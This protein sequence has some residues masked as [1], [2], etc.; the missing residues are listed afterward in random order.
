MDALE[1]IFLA[2]GYRDIT[3]KE[4]AKRLGCSFRRLYNIAD[5]KESLFL[6]VIDR[7]FNAMKKSGWAVSSTSKP[8]TTRVTDYLQVGIQAASRAGDGFNRDIAST[9]AG[10]LLFDSL[11]KERIS[12][13]KELVQEGIESG[14]FEKYHAYF[15]A[16]VMIQ[17]TRRVREPDFLAK[18]GM[19][20]SESLEE[21]SKLLRFGLL[22][23]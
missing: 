15:V 16:E 2:E 5:S 12:G 19:T 6:L 23:R 17:V 9:K 11:Q 7:F 14:E 18:S 20:F 4:L 10:Q 1:E 21:L 8:L 22:H 13:L 3:Q